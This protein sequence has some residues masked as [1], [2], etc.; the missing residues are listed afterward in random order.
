MNEVTFESGR[1]V[2]V[3]PWMGDNGE[4]VLL[5]RTARRTLICPPV[6]VPHGVSRIAA[7]DALW[8]QLDIV[9]PADRVRLKVI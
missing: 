9:D 7:M 3:A 6:T 5:A 8:D 1:G 2:F 4:L